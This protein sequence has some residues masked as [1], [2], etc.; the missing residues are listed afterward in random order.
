MTT[1][2]I[3]ALL[4]PSV[5]LGHQEVLLSY[6]FERSIPESFFWAREHAMHAAYGKAK[7]AKA[8]GVSHGAQTTLHWFEV[9]GR[10]PKS[11]RVSSVA[12]REEI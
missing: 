6:I 5:F 8:L 4:W 3:A 9:N 11:R 7:F 10:R 2:Y 12:D 1:A